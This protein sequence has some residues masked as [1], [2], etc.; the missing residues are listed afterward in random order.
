MQNTRQQIKEF[1]QEKHSASAEELARALQVTPANVR[2][3]LS[4]LTADGLVKK[5]GERP[6]TGRGRPVQ[7]YGLVEIIS[8]HNLVP[9][10]NT[11]LREFEEDRSTEERENL[12]RR[13]AQNLAGDNK[14]KVKNPGQRFFQAIQFLNTMNYQAR[15]E[16]HANAPHVIFSHC[17]YWQVIQEN[18]QLCRLDAYLLEELLGEEASQA[19][20]L[21]LAPNGTRQCV[22]LVGKQSNKE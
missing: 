21:E 11:L 16:A 17:P 22:F 2:H 20:K 14:A 15:W 6:S 18:P 3:H 10:V 8:R 13:L 19:V 1:L 5:V 9:L 7:L 4:A 12:S